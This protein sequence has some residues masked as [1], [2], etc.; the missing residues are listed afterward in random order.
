MSIPSYSNIF[1]C[2]LED[3]DFRVDEKFEFSFSKQEIEKI[4]GRLGSKIVTQK[5]VTDLDCKK[6]QELSFGVAPIKPVH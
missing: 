6:I 5:G 2:N 3:I 1:D 4:S